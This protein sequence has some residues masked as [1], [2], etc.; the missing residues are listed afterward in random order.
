MTFTSLVILGFKAVDRSLPVFILQRRSHFKCHH[1]SF[2]PSVESPMNRAF[3]FNILIVPDEVDLLPDIAEEAVDF[4]LAEIVGAVEPVGA[5]NADL[6]LGGGA[7]ARGIE[8]VEEGGAVV[9]LQVVEDVAQLVPNYVKV[10]SLG[11][12]VPQVYYLVLSVVSHHQN[13]VEL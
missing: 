3:S 7:L 2:P 11:P 9:P 8:G 13:R 12:V 10:A 1:V 5:E 6:E 4:T